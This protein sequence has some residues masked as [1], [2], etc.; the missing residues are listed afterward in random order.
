MS[1]AACNKMKEFQQW[2]KGLI[3]ELDEDIES[4]KIEI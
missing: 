4:I 2:W 3:K 1:S